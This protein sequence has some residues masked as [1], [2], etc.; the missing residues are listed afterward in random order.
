MEFYGI[1]GEKL[2]HS[3]S[4]QIHKRVFELLDIE[5]AYKL[6]EIP[7]DKINNLVDALKLL[8]IKGVNVTIPYKET[9]ISQL[10]FISKEAKSIGAVNTILI[11]DGKANGYNTDYFGFGSMLD[12]NNIQVQHKIAVVLGSGGASKAITTYLLDNQVKSLYLVTRNKDS[13][14]ELDNRITVIDYE[15]LKTIKGDI[16]INTTP[17]GMYPKVSDSPVEREII[18]NFQAIVDIIYNPKMTEFLRLGEEFGKVTCGGLYMLVGQG[19]KAEEIWQDI[20]IKEEVLEKVYT[21]LEKE[22]N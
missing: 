2:S 3:L 6:F 16:I 15:E 9:V 21:E 14:L 4:P 17:V 20:K 1:I 8:N 5:G 7:K 22:F 13:N 19:I 12:K 11:K 10:D 18:N